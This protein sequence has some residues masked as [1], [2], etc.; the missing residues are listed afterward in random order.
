VGD[1]GDL[2]I[3]YVTEAGDIL[4]ETF[5]MVVLAVGMEISPSTQALAE[6]L[7]VKLSRYH[8]ANH[9]CFDPVATSRP[10]FYA[11]G[12]LTGPKDIPQ[13][14]REG[15]AAAA[16]ATRHLASARGTL[17]KPRVYPPEQDVWA[18]PARVGVFVCNC[19]INIG[20]V[21]DVPAI[22]DYAGTLPE[23]VY[24]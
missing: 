1:T 4:T 18:Q 20:G 8:F 7:G 16:A 9:S 5:E 12:V 10:G 11:C 21:V 6:R 22:V 19:G 23:V 17:L 13:S 14:V 2:S 15:S 3:T 24:T